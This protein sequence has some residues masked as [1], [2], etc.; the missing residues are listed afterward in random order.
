LEY[1]KKQLWQTGIRL[2]TLQIPFSVSYSTIR[3]VISLN[4]HSYIIKGSSESSG[5]SLHSSQS[6]RI[7]L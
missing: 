5:R 2:Y 4:L 3:E 7:D 1:A 6:N